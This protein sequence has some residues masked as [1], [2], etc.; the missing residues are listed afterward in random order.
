M[1]E[2]CYNIVELRENITGRC[3]K[4]KEHSYYME[5]ALEEARRAY[6]KGEVPIGAV[7]VVDGE[8]VARGRNTREKTQQALNHAEMIAIKRAC[9]KQ[10]FWRLDNSYLYTTIEPCVMCSGAI[11]QARV[12]NVI[13]GA[14]DPK[15]GCCGSCMDLVSDNKFN[16]QA[17][18]ISG[19]LEDECSLLMKNFFK[20]LRENKKKN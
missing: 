10:G 18:V 9:E 4:L 2:I 13:Y 14:K 20:E 15:Y 5:L 16:H 8:V 3:Y 6:E 12:E 7:L 1:L 19:V 17:T 11:V